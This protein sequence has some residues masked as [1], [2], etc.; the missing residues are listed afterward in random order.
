MMR[1]RPPKGTAGLA[2]SAVNGCRREPIPP[3]R[4]M[5]IVFSSMRAFDQDTR[6]YVAFCR[7]LRPAVHCRMTAVIINEHRVKPSEAN[8]WGSESD[9]DS[10]LGG[11]T[12]RHL[13]LRWVVRLRY[14]LIVGEVALIAVLSF[15][16]QI[17]LPVI[18]IAPAI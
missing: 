15:G 18:V 9:G 8:F 2:L 12:A 3:A 13:A 5:L 14:G 6:L 16:L 17:A 11:E 10:R 7:S 4:M 1:Y